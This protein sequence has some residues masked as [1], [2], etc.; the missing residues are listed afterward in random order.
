MGNRSEAAAAD[1]ADGR[2]GARTV[3]RQGRNSLVLVLIDFA[4]D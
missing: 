3:F 2:E 4:D 1:H